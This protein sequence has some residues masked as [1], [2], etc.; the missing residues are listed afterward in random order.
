MIGKEK[1]EK[2]R[3]KCKLKTVLLKY[4]FIVLRVRPGYYCYIFSVTLIYVLRKK[5]LQT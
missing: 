2:K 5:V 1:M 4:T 3:T